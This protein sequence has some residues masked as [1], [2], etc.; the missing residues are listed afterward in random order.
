MDSTQTK[1]EK[2]GLIPVTIK[3]LKSAE[4]KDDKLEFLGVS[5]SEITFCGFVI[6]FKEL[7]TRTVIGIWDQTGFQEVVFYN[8]SENEQHTGLIG[9]IYNGENTPVRIFGKAKYYKNELRIDG[10]KIM[11]VD[12]NEF[13]YHKI[14]LINDWTYLT[15]RETEEVSH[16]NVNQN[17]KNNNQINSFS[18]SK[19]YKEKVIE[20]IEYMNKVKGSCN[21]EDIASKT[22]LSGHDLEEKLNAMIKE[23]SIYND[24]G[25]YINI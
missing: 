9:F 2:E 19:G 16:F 6:F 21:T 23:S 1:N 5:V 8:K 3:I 7:D 25:L 18:S 11:K 13:I 22:G 12:V 14:V 24:G 15:S 17:S 10:A 4:R 20:A